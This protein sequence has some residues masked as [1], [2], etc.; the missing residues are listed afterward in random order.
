VRS[1]EKA[2]PYYHLTILDVIQLLSIN[3]CHGN[4]AGRKSNNVEELIHHN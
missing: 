4:L 3:I 1:F 2:I